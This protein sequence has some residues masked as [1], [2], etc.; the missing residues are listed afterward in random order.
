MMKRY[1]IT[2]VTVLCLTVL[3]SSCSS[4]DEGGSNYPASISQTIQTEWY[5]PEAARYMSFEFMYVKGTVYQNL[6]DH[7]EIAETFSGQWIYS[8]DGGVLNMNVLYD[9]SLITKTEP[10]YVLHCDENTLKLRHA[11]LSLPIDFYR[12][13]ESYEARIGDRIDIAYVKDHLAFSSATYTT[14]NANIA[15][16]DADGRITVKGGGLAFVTVSAEA[17]SVVVKVDGGQRVDS[18]TAEVVETIDQVIAR[19]GETELTAENNDGTMTAFFVKPEQI[20]D[21]AVTQLAYTY[22]PATHVIIRVEIIYKQD[23]EKWFLYDEDYLKSNF[24]LYL[25]TEG[26][27]APNPNIMDNHYF[28]QALRSGSLFGM[29]VYN[30]G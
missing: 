6:S 3:L 12:V 10:Y 20:I 16:V 19:H 27:Y 30:R 1:S 21:H 4:D 18:Y 22:D 23:A 11:Q 5:A 9:K 28:I 2:I 15:D 17:G 26:F 25:N 14:S 29:I 13:V 7:P 24:Y 8:R